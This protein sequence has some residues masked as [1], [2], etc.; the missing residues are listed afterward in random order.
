MVAKD[1]GEK[2]TKKEPKKAPT[3]KG[4]GQLKEAV[5]RVPKMPK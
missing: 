2:E 1:K 5:W 4:K 3:P